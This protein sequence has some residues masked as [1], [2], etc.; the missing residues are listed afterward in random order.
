MNE[1]ASFRNYKTMGTRAQA[2]KSGGGCRFFGCVFLLLLSTVGLYGLLQYSNYQSFLKPK[3]SGDDKIAFEVK[4]G[5]SV[6]SIASRLVEQ[7]ILANKTVLTYPAYKIF[8]KLN[9]V[10]SSEIQAGVHQ[11]PA[12]V[13]PSEVFTYLRS[14]RCDEVKV[15]LR[16]GLRIEEFADEL[17]KA[18]KGKEKAVFSKS[19][20][21][22]IAKNYQGTNKYSINLPKNLEGYLFPDTYNFCAEVKTADVVERLLANFEAKVL[23]PLQ[24]DIAKSSR[25]FDQ[26]I[27]VAAML[28][29]EARGTDEKKIVAGIILARLE[30][31]MPLGIDATTQYEYGYSEKQRTWWRTGVELDN[32]IDKDGPYNTRKRAGVPPTPIANPGVDAIKAVLTPTRTSNLYYITG[33]DG[34][35]YYAKDLA[36]HNSNICRYLTMQCR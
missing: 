32:V 14:E 28:E 12:S 23:K 35:M 25:S 3:A 21:I 7:G 1:A 2:K 27:N 5:E 13:S 16:E 6:D 29:R 4:P 24:F 15:T 30:Q 26:V 22:S 20:F 33:K 31:G 19:E 17:D 18:F 11:I 9:E 10:N 34:M 8:L 36:G